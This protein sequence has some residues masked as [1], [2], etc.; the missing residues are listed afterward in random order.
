[1]MS[2][3][4][5]TRVDARAIRIVFMG[6]PAFAVPSLRAVHAAG[7]DVVAAVSQPDRPSGRGRAVHPPEVKQAALEL[8]IEAYQPESLRESATVERLAAF[9]ADVFVVAAYGKILPRSVL[10]LPRRGCINVHGSLLPRWRG[11]SPISAAILAGDTETGV[12]IMELVAKMDGGPVISRALFSLGPDAT[13]GDVEQ[14]LAGLGATELVRVLP[15][16]LSGEL[17]AEPQDESLVTYC[18]LVAKADGHLG[19]GLAVELAERAVRAYN[20]WPGAFVLY[21]GDRLNI[22]RA[23]TAPASVA[24]PGTMRVIERQPA[25]AFGGG[26]LVLD[27]VQRTGSRRVMGDQFVNGERGQLAPA[28]GLA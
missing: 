12:S 15:G 27:E 24:A 10:Q 26:W 1:M 2:T 8:G 4:G 3:S 5:T 25:I 17:R 21:R 9:D 14:A 23:H 11:P 6:S 19:A 28:A 16:W 13:T 20:P 7:Y 18:H 22:W